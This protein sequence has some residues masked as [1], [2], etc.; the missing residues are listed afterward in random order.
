[1]VFV[2]TSVFT[3]RIAR[4]GL[5]DALR[6]LQQEL[7]ENPTAG[8]LDPGTGG[9]RKVRMAD[10]TR[11]KGKRGGARVHYLWLPHRGMIYLLF[12]YSKDENDTL[13][14]QQ[15]KEEEGF[16]SDLEELQRASDLL[17]KGTLTGPRVTDARR[18]VLLS[19]T[20]KLQT[21]AQLLVVKKQ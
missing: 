15:K 11:G 13:S 5:E 7:L 19:S 6:G 9:V 4:L 17:A 21:S 16:Q 1:M 18:A 14:E 20:R 8:D 10:P 12:A 2:E 3:K